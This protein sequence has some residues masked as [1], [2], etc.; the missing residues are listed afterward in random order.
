MSVGLRPTSL[1]SGMLIHP[2]IWAQQNA[3]ETGGFTPFWR[4]GA[5]L[6][7]NLTQCGQGLR[8]TCMPSFILIHPTIW[9]LATIHQRHRQTDRT[10]R[11]DRQTDRQRSDSIGRTTLQMVAQKRFSLC[12]QTVVLSCPVCNV[13][14]LWPNDWKDY[15]ENGTPVGLVPG[16]IV[17][18][19][20]PAELP[21]PK[22]GRSPLSFLRIC[23]V[24][25]WLDGSRWPLAG[26]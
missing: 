20:D 8:P 18:D 12:Y 2:A 24:A 10:D 21:S 14:V 5:Q 22:T 1:P 26:K 3:Q 4:R 19:W 11:Q 15:D 6:G 9:H 25:K 13:G 7:P 17:L 16:H 23:V